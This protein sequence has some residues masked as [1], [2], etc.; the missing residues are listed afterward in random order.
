MNAS[1]G[2]STLPNCRSRS[3]RLRVMLDCAGFDGFG[4]HPTDHAC[5]DDGVLPLICPTCQM[6]SQDASGITPASTATL[7]GVV[8][9]I[10]IVRSRKPQTGSA[11]ML[12]RLSIRLSYP[13]SAP[14]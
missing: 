2:K 6:I 10:F 1:C 4:K 5:C 14:R 7:H 13:P 3:L 8:F 11:V 9:D 12:A